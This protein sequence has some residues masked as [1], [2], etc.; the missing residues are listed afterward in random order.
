M[1][2]IGG[3]TMAKIQLSDVLKKHLKIVAYLLSFGLG[4]WFARTY[5]TANETLQIICGGAVDYILWNLEQELIKN[6][7][8][9]AAL[10]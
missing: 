2:T 10:K 6:E 9:R 5:L 8:F 1:K 3:D 4:T 7:G